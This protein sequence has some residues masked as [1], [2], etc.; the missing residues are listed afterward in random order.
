[1]HESV[2]PITK[3]YFHNFTENM[4]CQVRRKSIFAFFF[5]VVEY[6]IGLRGILRELSVPTLKRIAQ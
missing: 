1:M 5:F 3:L 4:E 2:A 6:Y